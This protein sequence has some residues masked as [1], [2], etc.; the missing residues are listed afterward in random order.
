MF[1]FVFKQ[2][3]AYELR[4]SDWSSDVCSSDLV[5]QFPF[6]VGIRAAR[7]SQI[8]PWH[9]AWSGIGKPAIGVNAAIGRD[10]ELLALVPFGCLGI[11]HPIEHAS[12]LTRLLRNTVHHG[13]GLHPSGFQPGRPDTVAMVIIEPGL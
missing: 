10:F 6:I 13:G 12:A 1:V 5:E 3:T 7:G 2:K 8:F 11:S 4:I 9:A